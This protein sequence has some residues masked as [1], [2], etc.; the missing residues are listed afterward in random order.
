MT[1]VRIDGLE[2]ADFWS[3]DTGWNYKA[4]HALARDLWIKRQNNMAMENIKLLDYLLTISRSD[5]KYMP[6]NIRLIESIRENFNAECERRYLITP[7]G[8]LHRAAHG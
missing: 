4:I 1:K 8:K 3:P 7:F 5:P 2:V 6:Q